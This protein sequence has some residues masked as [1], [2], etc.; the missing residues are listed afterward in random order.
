[1]MT[2]GG[3]GQLPP[4]SPPLLQPEAATN[5]P[6]AGPFGENVASP[7]SLEMKAWSCELADRVKKT[8]KAR[9]E[10]VILYAIT[11]PAVIFLLKNI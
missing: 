3:G 6:P 7:N 8:A 1:M 5:I 9:K 11:D 2:G 4:P 10:R